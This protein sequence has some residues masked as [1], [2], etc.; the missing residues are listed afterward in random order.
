MRSSSPCYRKRFR[1]TFVRSKPLLQ[2]EIQLV[3]VADKPARPAEQPWELIDTI[4]PNHASWMEW[5]SRVPKLPLLPDFRQ[6]PLGNGKSTNASAPGPGVGRVGSG[7]LA[8]LS[9][10]TTGEIGKPHVLGG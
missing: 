5:L 1:D 9:R 6:E 8:S 10:S 3:V 7:R 2:R 4:D